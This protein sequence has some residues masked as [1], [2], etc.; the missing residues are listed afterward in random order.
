MK[1]SL[2]IIL[3]IMISLSASSQ[4]DIGGIYYTP[5]FGD[6]HVEIEGNTFKYISTKMGYKRQRTVL[7]ANYKWINKR[8][9]QLESVSMKSVIDDSLQVRQLETRLH[10]DSLAVY[11][12]VPESRWSGDLT[13]L[14]LYLPK[15]DKDGVWKEAFPEV[16]NDYGSL[17]G[18]KIMLPAETEKI[19]LKIKPRFIGGRYHPGKIYDEYYLENYLYYTSQ[20]IKVNEG[21]GTI[22]FNVPELSCFYF[23]YYVA[24]GE[25][26][27][28]KKDKIIWRGR[29]FDRNYVERVP[30]S[31]LIEI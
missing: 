11:V 10:N 22:E 4:E 30:R 21:V 13:C 24:N 12:T 28:V 19:V 29:V 31:A 3:M 1:G 9:I 5:N 16:E 14:I 2:L 8:F 25:Y 20:E 7:R 26:V 27:R 17:L 23:I 6:L 15:N 18:T